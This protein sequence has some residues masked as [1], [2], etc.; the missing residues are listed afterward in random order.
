MT[1]VFKKK[2]KHGVVYGFGTAMFRLE[3]NTFVQFVEGQPQ[4]NSKG[5]TS[6]VCIWKQDIRA[7]SL[8]QT[9]KTKISKFRFFKTKRVQLISRSKVQVLSAIISQTYSRFGIPIFS[10]KLEDS[11]HQQACSWDVFFHEWIQKGCIAFYKSRVMH[12]LGLHKCYKL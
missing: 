9:W 11:S 1:L 8:V 2:R 3:Y 5:T 6:H 4:M 7:S 12:P 10:K